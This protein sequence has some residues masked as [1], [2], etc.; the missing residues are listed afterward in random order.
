MKEMRKVGIMGGTFDP[1]HIGHLILAESAFDQFGLDEVLVMPSGNPPH[2]QDRSGGA[3]NEQRVAMVRLAVA[4]NP[5][6]KLSLIEMHDEGYT[7]TANTLSQLKKE[8]PDTVYYFI[9]GADS[10]LQFGTWREPERICSLCRIIVAVRDHL[11]SHE[12]D[13]AIA[14]AKRDYG[15]DIET[16]STPNIDISSHMIREWIRVGRSCRYYLPDDV[17]TYIKEER[18]YQL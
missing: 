4:S 15:A 3:T 1:I 7:Y 18:I 14:A 5:H 8:N 11:P 16:L 9:L 17:Y 13:E 10:L 12:L 2:K 6:L